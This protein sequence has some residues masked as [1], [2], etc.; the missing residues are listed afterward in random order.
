MKE[1]MVEDAD[2]KVESYRKW[3]DLLIPL[4]ALLAIILTFIIPHQSQFAFLIL[5]IP[6]LIQLRR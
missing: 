4:C 1:G 2:P 5:F 6:P 3:K